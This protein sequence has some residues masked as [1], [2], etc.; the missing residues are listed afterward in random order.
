MRISLV[1]F[2]NNGIDYS[3]T[4]KFIDPGGDDRQRFGGTFINEG[5]IKASSLSTTCNV[6]GYEAD[7]STF[8][9]RLRMPTPDY[10]SLSLKGSVSVYDTDDD[11]TSISHSLPSILSRVQIR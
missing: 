10:P 4:L 2:T 3:G 1:G 11:E 6:D 5:S 8:T 7:Y 9:L